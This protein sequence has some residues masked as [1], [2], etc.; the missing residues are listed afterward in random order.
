MLNKKQ[1]EDASKCRPGDKITSPCVNCAMVN[2]GEK[3]R[4]EDCIKESATTALI[5]KAML[6]DITETLDTITDIIDEADN[7]DRLG[8]DAE[9][10][11]GVLTKAKCLAY[12]NKEET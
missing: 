1:L 11:L 12:F 3:Q 7:W 2:V 5:Y 6:V 9:H 10:I 8:L 4:L